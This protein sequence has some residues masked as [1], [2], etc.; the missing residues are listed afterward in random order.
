MFVGEAA[1]VKTEAAKRAG[2]SKHNVTDLFK[3]DGIQERI[4]ELVAEQ[5]VNSSITKN[6]ILTGVLDLAKNAKNDNTKLAAWKLLGQHRQI[7][8]EQASKDGVVQINITFE[9]VNCGKPRSHISTISEAE[10]SVRDVGG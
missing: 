8:T 7:W 5:Q 4:T 6:A 1:L 2:Y 9:G 10:G 3:R